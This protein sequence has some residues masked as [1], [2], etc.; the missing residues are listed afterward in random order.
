[1]LR[2]NWEHRRRLQRWRQDHWKAWQWDGRASCQRLERAETTSNARND[3]ALVQELRGHIVTAV[4][5]HRPVG[6]GQAIM[7]LNLAQRLIQVKLS[8]PSQGRS[9]ASRRSPGGGW[10][11]LCSDQKREKPMRRGTAGS[12]SIGQATR[13][14]SEEPDKTAGRKSS[15]RLG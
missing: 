5:F 14:R 11:G 10:P 15:V 13:G 9:L 6:T 12:L 4:K 1:M 7:A 8:P 2:G 3:L